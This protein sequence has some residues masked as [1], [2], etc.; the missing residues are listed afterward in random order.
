M[1]IDH[2]RSGMQGMLLLTMGVL[3]LPLLGG[4]EP[5]PWRVVRAEP[6][7]VVPVDGD[8]A[9][10][11]LVKPYPAK[12]TLAISGTYPGLP[13]LN[14][15]ADFKF[16][17]KATGSEVR[18]LQIVSP[19]GIPAALVGDPRKSVEV[20]VYLADWTSNTMVG[21]IVN[22]G[23]APADLLVSFKGGPRRPLSGLAPK[24]TK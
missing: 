1:R 3:A 24:T 8:Q 23:Y 22:R 21:P 17:A 9:I 18:P 10:T 4:A 15:G 19:K 7:Q 20:E 13:R 6:A 16:F 5:Q 2:I 12:V 14:I 11:V